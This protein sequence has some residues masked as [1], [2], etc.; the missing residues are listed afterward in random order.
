MMKIYDAENQILGRLSTTISKQLLKG[1]K[2]FVVNCEK[3]VISGNPQYTV[4]T[5]LQRVKRG[6][7]IHGPFF[8]RTP[9]GIF[10]RAVRGMLP[11][12]KP[13][14]RNAF[15]NLRVFIGLPEEF[16]NKNLEKIGLADASKLK[17]KYISIGD[18]S[19]A[20][21]AKKRW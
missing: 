7:P 4:S 5:Y 16:K 8:P 1:E 15:K 18:I 12:K 19:S 2:V 17:T 14:G 21:G 3:A 11:R 9:D 6:D 10:R 20:I 13:K